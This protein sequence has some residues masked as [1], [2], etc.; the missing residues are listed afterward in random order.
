LCLT[1]ACCVCAGGDADSIRRVDSSSKRV[2][3]ART[4]FLAPTTAAA[5]S[6]I[7]RG[8]VVEGFVGVT[9]ESGHANVAI[10][11]VVAAVGIIGVTTRQGLQL[12]AA[13]AKSTAEKVG[14]GCYHFHAVHALSTRQ[15]LWNSQVLCSSSTIAGCQQV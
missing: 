11:D 14:G 4:N 6:V 7:R 3:S 10:K 2:T 12:A 1:V 5:T 8:D 15:Q 13:I 9:L